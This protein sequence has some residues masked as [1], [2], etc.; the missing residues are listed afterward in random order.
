MEYQRKCGAKRNTAVCA[1]SDYLPV[2]DEGAC[3]GCQNYAAGREIV[4]IGHLGHPEVEGTMG[5]SDGGMHLSKASKM[6]NDCRFVRRICS[7][8]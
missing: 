1:C 8:T 2:G 3:R 7:L 5:Q 4:M 6:S